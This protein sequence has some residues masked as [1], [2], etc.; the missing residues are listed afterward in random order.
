MPHQE[1]TNTAERTGEFRMTLAQ[2][3]Y[4]I[5]TDDQFAAEWRSDPEAA[6]A[7]RGLKLSQ[8]ELNFLSKGLKRKDQEKT[9]FSLAAGPTTDAL[10]WMV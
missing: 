2:V 7:T 5:S 3:V 9:P 1:T 8:E 10:S 6:L 4:N